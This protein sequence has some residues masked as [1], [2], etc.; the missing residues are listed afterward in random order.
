MKYRSGLLAS[1]LLGALAAHAAQSER[2]RIGP[3]PDWVLPSADLATPAPDGTPV[4]VLLS[5]RQVR[6]TAEAV[7]NHVHSR[8]RIQTP[9]GLEMAGTLSFAWMPDSDVLTL[10]RLA[11]L[12]EGEV[13]DLLADEDAF[14]ILRREDQL[15]QAV[16][17]GM[18]TAVL[19]PE[20]LR[21]GDTIEMSYTLRRRDPV[22]HDKPD[23]SYVLGLGAA[24]NVRLR[25]LWPDSLRLRW[26]AT[27][28][29][30]P[31]EPVKTRGWNELSWQLD[32]VEP[33]LQPTGAPGRFAALR[34]LE[35]TSFSDWQALS[36]RLAPLYA[37]ASR[38]APDSPLRAEVERIRREHA[39]P[40]ARA[41]AALR[42]VQDDVRY[43]LLAMN[44]GGL[45]PADADETWRRRFGDC[46]AKSALLLALL[47]ELDIEADVVAVSTTFGDGLD[48]R[49]PGV[50][51]FDHVLV[52]AS[53][54]S[55]TYWLDGTRAGDRELERIQAPPFRWALPLV[56]RGSA[57]VP[58]PVEPLEEPTVV[59][60]LEVNARETGVTLPS[61]FNA[62][63][64]MWGDAAWALK[65][66]LDGAPESNRE[67]AERQF[68]RGLYHNLEV[69]KT[70][71]VFDDTRGIA[72]WTASGTIT[73]EW[74]PEYHTY[75]PHDMVL[76]Y[77]ADL[78]RPRGTDA[79]AP[80]EVAFPFYT[81]VTETIRLPVQRAFS[82]FTVTGADVDK[83][84]GGVHYLRKARVQDHSFITEVSQR[85]VAAEFPASERE[86]VERAL[87]EMSRNT[88]FLKKP[89]QYLPAKGELLAEST[90]GFDAQDYFILGRNM[91]DRG[92]RE[93]ARPMFDKALEMDPSHADARVFRSDVRLVLG[94]TPGAIADMEAVVAAMPD[95]LRVQGMFATLL[96]AARQ[97]S[98]ALEVTDLIIAAEPRESPQAYRLKAEALSGLGRRDEIPP[99]V[100]GMRDLL[101]PSSHELAYTILV[102]SGFHDEAR[103]LSGERMRQDPTPVDRLALA[104]EKPE[105]EALADLRKLLV[106]ADVDRAFWQHAM[107]VLFRQGRHA[108]VVDVLDEKERD[109]GTLD[110][111][112]RATRGLGKW[113]LG[114]EPGARVDL[115]AAS[116]GAS[117]SLLN[118]LCWDKTKYNVAL[119]VALEECNAAVAADPGCANCVDS[120]GLLFLRMGRLEESVQTYTRALE[121][122]PESVFSLFGRGTARIRLGQR[123]E[124]TQDIREAMR[125][126]PAVAGDFIMMNLAPEVAELAPAP[127]SPQAAGA[128]G[129]NLPGGVPSA[130]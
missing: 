11:V 96:I 25:M 59:M 46:K 69:E 123:E 56:A 90:E 67:E 15:E 52:R 109:N 71:M 72:T 122:K 7:E 58:I 17:T 29:L 65:R 24:N 106:P 49:L 27:S 116:K 42:L 5:D 13:Q 45:N 53:I 86:E 26:R 120:L 43:V 3:A 12:R 110:P 83:V 105:Q 33:L 47:R 63:V 66:M 9:Q 37:R 129:A 22:V 91:F 6:M 81:R 73:L 115:A 95:N 111:R 68:W 1:L 41:A 97:W 82:L 114:D 39:T 118:D 113:Q 70:E 16:L 62:R 30:P 94:D 85:S 54:G 119:S 36:R 104:L 60:S 18:L 127:G 10:H 84:V 124:G 51:L 75:E 102:A 32:R 8:I 130:R 108:A 21:V 93:Q 88:L 80:Y 64:T 128:E 4:Q 78:S 31:A 117:A 92:M 121:L 20:G 38:L 61:P 87:L 126:A 100:A 112:L 57:L 19:Q 76:G 34:M 125:I 35:V 44:D 50:G 23:A 14:T 74:D 101:G 48:A 77:R 79:T 98:R 55:K 28:H 103:A 40:E 99:L 2:P 89:E 107:L